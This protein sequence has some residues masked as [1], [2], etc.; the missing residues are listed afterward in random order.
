MLFSRIHDG[1]PPS[2][3]SCF[4]IPRNGSVYGSTD[5]ILSESRANTGAAQSRPSL[6]LCRPPTTPRAPARQLRQRPSAARSS[7]ATGAASDDRRAHWTSS[8]LHHSALAYFSAGAGDQPSSHP[9]IKAKGSDRRGKL[10]RRRTSKGAAQN[11]WAV[12]YSANDGRDWLAL[13]PDLVR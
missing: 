13:A 7:S 10:F 1:V 9:A 11:G 2:I 12:R 4:S 8:T 6:A 3:W 5:T